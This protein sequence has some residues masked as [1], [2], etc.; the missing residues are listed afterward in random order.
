MT[1]E[2]ERS[3]DEGGIKAF[4]VIINTMKDLKKI[5]RKLRQNMQVPERILWA[6]LRARRFENYKF[7]RQEQIDNYIVDFVC[8]EKRLI[9]ELDGRQHLTIEKIQEDE[10]RSMYLK[11]KG[12]NIVRYYNSDILNNIDTVLE[13]LWGNLQ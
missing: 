4:C 5:V 9:I 1:G 6:K 7:R 10:A 12:F 3:S 2:A 8:Y 13:D 11:E